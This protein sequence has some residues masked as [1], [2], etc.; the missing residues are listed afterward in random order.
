MNL[1]LKKHLFIYSLRLQIIIRIT[2]VTRQ[3]LY[4]KQSNWKMVLK[5]LRACQIWPESLC[6]ILTTS[7][8]LYLGVVLL[9]KYAQSTFLLSRLPQ[10]T[11]NRSLFFRIHNYVLY[12]TLM[13]RRLSS[14][15][16]QNDSNKVCTSNYQA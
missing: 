1:V 14:S 11:L 2:R 4:L 13:A 12:R 9:Y 5:L 15:P 6:Y 7:F 3:A 16:L 10:N 8:C